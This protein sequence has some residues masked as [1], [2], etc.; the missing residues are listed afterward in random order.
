VGIRESTFQPAW[1]LP[2]PHL[3][4]IFP[5]LARRRVPLAARRQTFELP[6][7]DFVELAW[8]DGSANE[9]T[10]AVLVLHG[11]EGSIDSPYVRGI[12][13]AIARRGWRAVLLHFR[14]CAGAP[15]RLARAYH[16]GETGDVRTIVEY[17]ARELPRAPLAIIGYS[18]GGNV[19][20]KYLGEEGAQARS[21]VAG[22]VAVSVPLLLAPCADRLRRGF[23]RVY[24]RWLLRSLRASF[25]RKSAQVDL[26]LPLSRADLARISCL[27]E[28]DDKITAPLHGFAGA[29]DYYQ[30]SSSRPYLA[31][32]EVPTLILQ[33]RDDP[34]MTEAVLP[35]ETELSTAVTLELSERGGHVGFISGNNPFAP[36]Y[37]LERRIPEFLAEIF[38]QRS[39]R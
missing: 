21:R 3:A 7:G 12:L 24:D 4:T 11:L 17:L 33:A 30:R 28:F 19:L 37:W 8:V 14:G 5:A 29:D 35:A 13:A 16:S 38:G 10:P 22:A 9:H 31:Q 23:S 20:L 27:R 18:L 25:R 15:N 36:E 6:D 39:L 2:G 32:I 26:G 34:F 1:W